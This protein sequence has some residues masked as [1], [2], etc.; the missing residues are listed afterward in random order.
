MRK[1]SDRT[2][3]ALRPWKFEV[4]YLP[5]AEA[6]VLVD[7]GKTRV[8]CAV[9]VEERQPPWMSVP[10]RGW[11]K[12]EY[13]MLP[14]ATH[15]RTRRDA[16]RSNGRTHEIQRLIG[17]SLRG[18]VNLDL[19]GPRTLALDCDVLIAD[20]GTRTASVT[21]GWV[22]LVMACHR[23]KEK[24]KISALPVFEQ[25]AAVSLG[26]V[27]GEILT[28]LDY[29]EDSAAHTDLNLVMTSSGGIVEVQGTAEGEPFSRAELDR[30]L[31]AGWNAL[32]DLFALQRD[33]LS[34]AGCSWTATPSKA[35]LP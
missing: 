15:Q 16:N 3:S 10:N 24:G 1:R 2:S 7:A 34:K 31:D 6:S 12:A 26:I 8:L 29:L 33:T 9:S 25:V 19:I 4:D 28:D 32:Q 17:R 13:A 21:A 20:A 23:L 14:M 22:A 27:D 11:V 5:Y 18:V 35:L 30:I